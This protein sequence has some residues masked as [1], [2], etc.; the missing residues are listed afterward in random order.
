MIGRERQ[1][2]RE[3]E[4]GWVGWRGSRRGR[5]IGRDRE[6]NWESERE[7]EGIESGSGIRRGRGRL[8]LGQSKITPGIYWEKCVEHEAAVFLGLRSIVVD[9]PT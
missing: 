1:K 9:K 5:C 2:G 7:R 6:K 4:R 8:G 3:R